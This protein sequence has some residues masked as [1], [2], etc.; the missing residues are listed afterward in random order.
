MDNGFK[1][2]GKNVTGSTSGIH[3]RGEGVSS[4]KPAG[5]DVSY[6][7]RT[8]NTRPSGYS[9]GYQQNQNGSQ[10]QRSTTRGLGGGKLIVI[11]LIAVLLFGGGGSFLGALLGSSSSS[12]G[13]SG[14]SQQGG[15]LSGLLGGG[16]GGSGGSILSGIGGLLGGSGSSSASSGL[17]I[18]SL[19]GGFS[20]GSS[21][22]TGWNREANVGTLDKTVASGARAKYTNVLGGGKDVFTIMVYL[23]GTDL[24]SKS[25]M[26][27]ND[28]TEMA[29]A[30]IGKN[31]NIIVYTGGCKQWKTKGISNSV[32]QIYKVESGKL[33]PLVDNA[34][35]ASMVEPDNLA[36]FIQ[37][38]TKNYPANR[39]A[40][41]FWDHGGGSVSGYGYDEKNQSAG[42]MDLA[43]I[44]AALKKGGTTFDFIGFDACLMA[45][46]ETGLM[47]NDYADY[48]I[49]SEETEP[50]IGWYYT[51]WVTKL[52]QNTSMSTLELGKNIVDD[53]VSECNRRCAGQKTT[54]SVVDLAEL[55][56]TVPA[57]LKSFAT[58]TSKLLNDSDYKAVSDARSG[59][60]EFA[61]SSRIDQV[62][63]VNLCDN[64]GTKESKELAEALLG[65]VKYN[66]TSSSISNAYGISIYFP[67]N[68]TSYVRT[69]VK[70]YDS[71]G[72]GDEY[73]RCIQQ[74]AK[75]ETGG[76]S[77]SSS[78]GFDITSLLGGSAG[79]SA[80]SGGLDISSILG[81]LGGR[82]IDLSD[83]AV[84][85]TL[86]D[87]YFDASK[88]VWTKENG[89]P[90]IRLDKAQWSQVHDLLLNV[91][92]D[93]GE[94]YLNLGL[95][96]M[97]YFTKDGALVGLYDCTWVAINNQPVMF[98]YVDTL[99]D[100]ATMITTGTV[101]ILL[102]DE[103]ADL[104]VVFENDAATGDYKNS[105]VAGVRFSYDD[106]SDEEPAAVA[107][108]AELTAGDTIEFLCDYYTYAGE[109]SDTYR[110]GDPIT[111]D[112]AGLT[113]SYT[114]FTN[115]SVLKAS[116]LFT[117]I[118]NNE[119]WTA[120][121]LNDIVKD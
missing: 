103:R 8:E 81:L 64:L 18:T 88:L 120:L 51:N 113:V 59:T 91:W 82:S 70:T 90:V 36:G 86:T 87:N 38:C 43:E 12:S 5:K 101:P 68:R 114:Q 104:L 16:S 17:D 84:E 21:V 107:K 42:T 9:G 1:G 93:D 27:T 53:F 66:K 10:T 65:A 89:V 19:L 28:L 99:V 100:G 56:A 69:A 92:Y 20:G 39:Q 24:E 33:I 52:S 67:Y 109:F 6:S 30:T 47:L 73:S 111:Y 60:R 61:E 13:S 3:K 102:N 35:T 76:Q 97:Y 96:S 105:Y 34:G 80:S 119:H 62:D 75:L 49:A 23:C 40:L 22:S 79:S 41:I 32:N 72:L 63:L 55:S 108:A 115:P 57:E 14:G 37:F 121:M 45:T 31:V 116:Y 15:L 29:N 83:E 94:G 95:D 112:E 106:V 118:Y 44:R 58:S 11:V 110:I 50:G 4:G 25:G 7:R 46:L 85:Q 48:L 78:S 2:R 26:A 117:D 74:F 71:I 98:N 54:L 77:A